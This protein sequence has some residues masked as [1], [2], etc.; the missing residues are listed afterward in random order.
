MTIESRD[1]EDTLIADGVTTQ[2]P[3]T[4]PP[5]ITTTP[6][7]FIQ[8]VNTTQGVDLQR[9]TDWTVVLNSAGIGGVVTLADPQDN[10]DVIH[11][12]R[13]VPPFQ[14]VRFVKEGEISAPLLE[15]CLDKLTVLVQQIEENVDFIR[16]TIIPSLLSVEDPDDVVVGGIPVYIEDDDNDTIIVGVIEP[17]QAGYV[18]TDNGIGEIPTFQPNV[19]TVIDVGS[20]VV[21]GVTTA[22]SV[23]LWDA[24]D[25]TAIK[26]GP[27]LGSAND[28]FVSQGAGA[29]PAFTPFLTAF[30]TAAPGVAGQVWTSNGPG[31][32]GSFEDPVAPAGSGDFNLFGGVY[33]LE[34]GWVPN[35]AGN[36][37][38]S[39]GGVNLTNQT[40]PSS[41]V[42]WITS[43]AGEDAGVFSSTAVAN[44][45]FV[46]VGQDW[47]FR[48]SINLSA[49][50]GTF[51]M[52]FGFVSN[53]ATQ[54]GQDGPQNLH[55][56]GFRFGSATDTTNDNWRTVT[57][58]GGN[59]AGTVEDSNVEIEFD[60]TAMTLALHKVGSE[61]RFYINDILVATHTTNL[62]NA[63]LTLMLSLRDIG[64]DGYQLRI[65][66]VNL[67][68]ARPG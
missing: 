44:P 37:F 42:V 56:C 65:N 64:G 66:G 18:L 34:L 58:D 36:G 60:F 40:A 26:N 45:Q 3:F 9:G 30:R 51:R 48:T 46:P 25:G 10:L 41:G 22:R 61:V 13:L 20:L 59:D 38:L 49:T 14:L 11:I 39:A 27:A 50:P 57:N 19:I 5:L 43:S 28:V 12:Y 52:F 8:V 15:F 62:P 24:A 67:A 32:D 53:V 33:A 31:V 2:F 17:V 68:V 63:A 47:K 35:L 1:F 23:V 4:F 21:P 6:G 54:E 16:E 29:D 7:E 55:C